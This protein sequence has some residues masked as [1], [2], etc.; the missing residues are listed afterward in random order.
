M[1]RANPLREQQVKDAALDA[2]YRKKKRRRGDHQPATSED[3]A[4][5]VQPER[6]AGRDR[7]GYLNVG[8]K[9]V[10]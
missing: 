4:H 1:E 10:S 6:L 2:A 9:Y 7:N 8:Q 3:D 5:D